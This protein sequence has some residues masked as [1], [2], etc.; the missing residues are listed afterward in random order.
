MIDVEKYFRA[1]KHL[2]SDQ[3]VAIKEATDLFVSLADGMNELPESREKSLCL[4]KLQEAKF[5]A[6]ECIAKNNPDCIA[7]D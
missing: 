4:T 6:I 3:M 5:W 7:E 1:A 2:S